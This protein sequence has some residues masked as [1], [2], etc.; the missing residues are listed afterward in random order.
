MSGVGTNR[1]TKSRQ[2]EV[3]RD[4]SPAFHHVF[5]AIAAGAVE[6][7]ELNRTFPA[8]GKYAPLDTMELVNNSTEQLRITINGQV[9]QSRIAPGGTVVVIRNRAIHGVTLLNQDGVNTTA[10]DEVN[11]TF[12][13]GAL[14]AD[15]EARRTRRG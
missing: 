12:S 13:R 9:A 11:A 4:G 5:S 14:T 2:D 8:S 3:D 7:L 15:S 1:L 6:S 10:A